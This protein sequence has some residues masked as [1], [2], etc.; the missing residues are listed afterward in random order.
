M[1]YDIIANNSTYLY[2]QGKPLYPF[3]YGLSYSSFEYRNM[4]VTADDN[5]KTINIKT[6]VTNTSGFDGDEVVQI[7]YNLLNSE[8]KR[9]LR[10]LCGFKRVHIPRGETVSVNIDIPYQALEFYD[11]SREKLCTVSGEYNFMAGASCLDIRLNQ[12]LKIT[13]EDIPPR[14]LGKFIKA[15][16]YDS[17]D[18][19]TLHFSKEYNDH[20]VVSGGWGGT[21][22]FNN[23]D[24]KDYSHIKITAC[25]GGAPGSIS[26]HSGSENSEAMGEVSVLSAASLHSFS[27]YKIPLVKFSGT[28]KL[29]LK[30]K[31]S[32]SVYGF[33]FE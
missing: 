28:D 15:K 17:R 32:V 3:G 11:V 5:G 21:L 6:E 13:A 19:C 12:T 8:V 22:V 9:P 27:E 33:V 4:T 30:L 16:N 14:D 31:G 26:V 2:Y 7:Y 1:D 23:A 10:K 20:Y 24:F 25:S 29:V 18:N